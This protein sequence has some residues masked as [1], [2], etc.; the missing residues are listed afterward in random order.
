MGY[1]TKSAYRK[2]VYISGVI[3]LFLALVVAVTLLQIE[4]RY[5]GVR[6]RDC[7]RILN[8]LIKTDQ[9]PPP[10]W[11]PFFVTGET[12][13]EIAQQLRRTRNYVLMCDNCFEDYVQFFYR[14]RQV[15]PDFHGFRFPS[16]AGETYRSRE[17]CGG[18]LS[19]LALGFQ[20]RK[21]MLRF[22]QGSGRCRWLVVCVRPME[23]R[24]R[25]QKGGKEL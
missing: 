25:K 22:L 8:H 11:E 23:R 24:T 7:F 13:D 12:Y 3:A 19:F 6:C 14:Q 16:G 18:F 5:G 2:F 21:T 9:L 17:R 15:S 10:N 1:Q 20:R 4:R